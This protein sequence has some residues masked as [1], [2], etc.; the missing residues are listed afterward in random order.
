MPG[1]EMKITWY[2]C[3]VCGNEHFL[4]LRPDTHIVKFPA[5][6]KKCK[7]EIL[8]TIEPRAEKVSP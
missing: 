5:Y 8:V 3:P 7:K 4:K 1:D 6:C 2:K